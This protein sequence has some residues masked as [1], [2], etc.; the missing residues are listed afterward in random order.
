[1]RSGAVIPRTYITMA[2]RKK[3]NK[4][5]VIKDNTQKQLEPHKKIVKTGA[6]E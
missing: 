6:P 3:G 1:M 5:N 2:K 4:D